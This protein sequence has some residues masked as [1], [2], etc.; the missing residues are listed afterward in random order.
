[1]AIVSFPDTLYSLQARGHYG[2][3]RGYGGSQYGKSRRGAA[4]GMAG[5]YSRKVHG[6]GVF[7]APSK[8]GNRWAISRMRFYRPTNTQQPAQ[9]A[10]RGH[11]A[12]AVAAW[13]GLTPEARALHSRLAKKRHCSGYNLFIA[14]WLHAHRG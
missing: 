12:D 6:L 13:Q 4:D 14:S 3:G 5:I 1:M 7:G 8:R 10:W 9:Q 2:Y 11:F